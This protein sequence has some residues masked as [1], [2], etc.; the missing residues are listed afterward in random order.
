MTVESLRIDGIN[1][2]VELL[3]P[4]DDAWAQSPF[5]LSR[6]RVEK[7]NT[8]ESE[9]K[10]MVTLGSRYAESISKI[11]Q[12]C[13]RGTYS[14]NDVQVVMDTFAYFGHI[15]ICLSD[16]PEGNKNNGVHEGMA[17]F[18][19]NK[20]RKSNEL[21]YHFREQIIEQGSTKN[22]RTFHSEKAVRVST[23]LKA[24]VADTNR[25]QKT[26]TMSCERQSMIL[27]RVRVRS[28]ELE[29]KIK[30]SCN[31]LQQNNT[32]KLH[33]LNP[34]KRTSHKRTKRGR[35]SQ[36]EA[37]ITKCSKI[38]N[39]LKCTECGKT[40]KR[41]NHLQIHHRIH[42]QTR[43]YSCKQ[44]GKTFTQSSNLN[45]HLMTHSKIQPYA[46]KVCGRRF[47]RK[48]NLQRHRLLHTKEKP[49]KC[50]DCGKR[51]SDLGNLKKHYKVHSNEKPYLCHHCG[52]AFKRQNNLDVHLRIH[53]EEYLYFCK[54]CGKK[55]KQSSNLK[56]HQR[57]RLNERP[58]KCGIGEKTSN[59]V[60]NLR[61]HIRSHTSKKLQSCFVRVKMLTEKSS[62]KRHQRANT[63]RRKLP[64]DATAAG[65][66]TSRKATWDSISSPFQEK[67][68]SSTKATNHQRM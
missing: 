6:S 17:T 68:K 34:S 64:A 53:S 26:N 10:I 2:F 41:K 7:D 42:T 14:K 54:N 45:T 62:L 37:T 48:D 25:K 59:H 63:C 38:R 52:K 49:H 44:C 60:A 36:Y 66:R 3:D 5:L 61:K 24:R 46:C 31:S 13:E 21:Q 33:F 11:S 16:F 67:P 40:F 18:K 55:F 23:R 22:K 15:S 56:Q 57:I 47:S 43:P 8:S 50:N 39:H 30:K 20:N 29:C 65:M 4:G 32:P 9:E 12:R 28:K 58:N 19:N 35:R 51:F 27:R 1:A